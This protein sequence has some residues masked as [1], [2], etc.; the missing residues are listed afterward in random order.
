MLGVDRRRR[1]SGGLPPGALWAVKRRATG[2]LGQ[3]A[4]S[5]V[6]PTGPSRPDTCASSHVLIATSAPNHNL[7][8]FHFWWRG[9]LPGLRKLS[10]GGGAH[11]GTGWRLPGFSKCCSSFSEWPAEEYVTRVSSLDA[12]TG[13][14]EDPDKCRG[15]GQPDGPRWIQAPSF[16]DSVL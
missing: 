10:C 4:S 11:W 15:A 2:S 8:Q 6:L 9:H 3:P 14:T 5:H 16:K 13:T 7:S 1:Q 12:G